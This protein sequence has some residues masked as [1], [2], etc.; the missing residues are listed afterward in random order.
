MNDFKFEC[1]HCQQRIQVEAKHA[2]RQC[3]CPSC[4]HLIRVPAVPGTPEQEYNP[5][6]GMTWNTHL[7]GQVEPKKPKN[8]E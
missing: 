4:K 8:K 1:P 7:P 3:Q 2:G 5:Q 6:S